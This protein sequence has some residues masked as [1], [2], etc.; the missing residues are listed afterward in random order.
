M[1][2]Q[3]GTPS[4][5]I[6]LPSVGLTYRRVRGRRDNSP[7][8]HTDRP[9]PTQW[10]RHHFPVSLSC[11]AALYNHQPCV[12]GRAI[13]D[14]GGDDDCN[15]STDQNV[16][17][18]LSFSQTPAATRPHRTTLLPHRARSCTQCFFFSVSCFGSYFLSSAPTSIPSSPGRSRDTNAISDATVANLPN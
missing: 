4:D 1:K 13:H 18:F 5:I 10:S 12:R 3:S 2:K 9:H 15:S 11:P 6:I 16:F 8:G 14:R 17:S 7:R